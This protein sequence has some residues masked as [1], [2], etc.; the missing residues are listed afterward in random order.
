M[1]NSKYK[2]LASNT[3]LFAISNFGSKLLSF[4]LVP[5]YTFILT[6]EEYGTADLIFA[7]CTILLYIFSLAIAEGTMR[8]TMAGE[9]DSPKVLSN[10]VL[11]ALTMSVVLLLVIP[12]FSFIDIFASNI[13][14]MYFIVV[15][16]IFYGVITQFARGNDQVRIFA[17]A[18]ILQTAGVLLC[19]IVL[20]VVLRLGVKG[21]LVS[22]ALGFGISTIYA[23]VRIKAW[24]LCKISLI[25]KQYIRELL[26][27]SM[28]MIATGLSWWILNA[29][30]KYVITW[31]LGSGAN[32]VYTVAHKIPTIV[33]VFAAFFNSAWQLS[34]IN[35]QEN[36]NDTAF[37][38]NVFCMYSS[39]VLLGASGLILIVRY[40]LPLLISEGYY[41]AVSYV[42]L[43][44][45][46]CVFQVFANFYGG[47]NL[48]YRKTKNLFWNSLFAAAVNLVLNILLTPVMGMYGTALSTVIGCALMWGLRIYDVAKNMNLHIDLK[49]ICISL[50]MVTIQ[51]VLFSLNCGWGDILQTLVVMFMLFWHRGFLGRLLEFIKEVAKGRKV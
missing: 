30:D 7:T 50:V 17:E 46:A 14:I 27:Y 32:G 51:I 42:P 31:F 37:Y 38:N 16:Q 11:I 13:K 40:A 9:Y 18:G 29:S 12:L 47:F 39:M 21:Y 43:L 8:F 15:M 2:K 41:E 23:A 3:V 4:I 45:F 26:L 22:Y 48:A 35:E 10:S 49:R 28:P 24:R 36:G 34:A 33:T 19:N 6:T 25:D 1:N 20:L 5:V 44:V